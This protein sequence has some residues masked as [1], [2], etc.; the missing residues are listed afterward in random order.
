MCVNLQGGQKKHNVLVSC[1][2]YFPDSTFPVAPAGPE[3]VTHEATGVPT[4]P[5]GLGVPLH[6]RGRA[7]RTPDHVFYFYLFIMYFLSFF[8][9][10]FILLFFIIIFLRTP[11]HV[12][13][14]I[15][16]F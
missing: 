12:L 2:F 13:F 8:I 4:P 10:C 7:V 1:F 11:D 9:M 3:A 6:R 15:F 16:Y 14:F 5:P